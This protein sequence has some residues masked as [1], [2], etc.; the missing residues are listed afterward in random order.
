MKFSAIVF[1][2]AAVAA[3]LGGCGGGDSGAETVAPASPAATGAADLRDATAQAIAQ[4][5]G[6]DRETAAMTKLLLNFDVKANDWTKGPTLDAIINIYQRTR[7]PKYRTLIDTSFTY[8]KGWRSGDPNILYYDDMGW[9]ANAW[10]RAYDVTGDAKY[11]TEAEAIFVVMTQAWDSTC[12]GGLWWNNQRTYKNAIPNELFLL[13]AAR[14]ARRAPNGTGAGSYQD[15]AAK[16]ADWFVNKSGLINSQNLVND[17]LTSACKNNGE[18]TWSYNQGVILGGLAEMFRLTGNRGY[19]ASAERIGDA[20]TTLMVHTN[21]SFRDVCDSGPNTCTGDAVI[22]KGPFVQGLARL[23][24]AERTNRPQYLPFL[25]VSADSLWNNSRNA[26]NGLGTNWAGPVGVPS[27]SSQAS[28]LL[29][30]GEINLL[31]DFPLGEEQWQAPPSAGATYILVNPGSNMA[32]DVS[33]ASSADGTTV[34]LG[35]QSGAVTQEWTITA[36][37]DGTSTLVNSGSNKA[38]DVYHSLTADGTAVDIWTQNTSGAQKWK[39]NSN[40]D[41]TYTLVNPES[42]KALDVYSTSPANQVKIDIRAISGAAAQK[43]KLVPAS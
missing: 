11:L 42:N 27:Q 40:S 38:L 3:L 8:G 25:N 37:S 24:N 30:L 1:A 5:V 29:L 36:N 43:W 12:G 33:G 17:G 21:G 26:Q 16:T 32:L 34:D 22:F 4:S 41:G 13:L 14:L 39:F 28:G 2:V 35:A 15:W 18:A 20:A 6:E 9:Y 7:D 31:N 23:Y 19:L 10:L